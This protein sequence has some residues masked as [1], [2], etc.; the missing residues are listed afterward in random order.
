MPDRKSVECGPWRTTIMVIIRERVTVGVRER[1]RSS[2]T[3][4]KDPKE[5]VDWVLERAT[6]NSGT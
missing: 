4:G 2:G 1:R 3:F 6:E 5:W